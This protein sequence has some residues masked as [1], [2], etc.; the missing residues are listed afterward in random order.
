MQNKIDKVTRDQLAEA[1]ACIED[2]SACAFFACPGPDKKYVPMATCNVCRA[3]Q[4]LKRATARLGMSQAEPEPVTGLGRQM[5]ADGI[6]MDYEPW[7][8]P[9][10]AD[11]GEV[12]FKVTLRLKGRKLTVP[13]GMNN[14]M[15]RPTAEDVMDCLL[16][17]AS[18]LAMSYDEW[19]SEFMA[20]NTSKTRATWGRIVRQ[21]SKLQELLGDKLSLY[22]DTDW[23]A[24]S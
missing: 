23:E 10:W 4:L 1:L 12:W 18:Y 3:A 2:G 17:D 15:G 6:V 7:E 20:E 8:R 16:S 9:R 14:P 21:S 22:M 19:R 11:W 13:F 5:R 24:Q